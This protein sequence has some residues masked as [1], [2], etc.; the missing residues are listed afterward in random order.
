MALSQR[1]TYC[2]KSKN[3]S[4]V[5][6]VKGVIVVMTGQKFV[7]LTPFSFLHVLLQRP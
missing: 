3:G 2:K 5:Q 6:K 1:N 7:E 4:H